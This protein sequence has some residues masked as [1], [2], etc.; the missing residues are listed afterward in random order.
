MKHFTSDNAKYITYFVANDNITEIKLSTSRCYNKDFF[1]E[2]N[3]SIKIYSKEEQEQNYTTAMNRLKKVNT[4]KELATLAKDIMNASQ[5]A[6]SNGDYIFPYDEE[7]KKSKGNH[8]WDCYNLTK[9]QFVDET[10]KE[11]QELIKKQT[12]VYMVNK[13]KKAICNNSVLNAENSKGLHKQAED[14]KLEL[15]A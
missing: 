4:Y 6:Q 1:E 5:S 9:D 10:I 15:S 12:E 8:F 3:M 2:E 11:F 13:L 14:K 7:Q